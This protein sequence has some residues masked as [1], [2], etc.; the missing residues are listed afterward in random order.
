M[1]SGTGR[2]CV[3]TIQG[4][5]ASWVLRTGTAYLPLEFGPGAPVDAFDKVIVSKNS[6]KKMFKNIFIK[7][8]Y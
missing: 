8:F 1:N 3:S 2:M 7:Y 6:T 4:D 5:T